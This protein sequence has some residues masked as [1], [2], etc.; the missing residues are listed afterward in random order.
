[1]FKFRVW[2]LFLNLSSSL[3]KDH[4]NI[5]NFTRIVLALKMRQMIHPLGS[6]LALEESPAPAVFP[7]PPDESPA[8]SLC[9]LNT[10]ETLKIHLP[11]SSDCFPPSPFQQSYAKRSS[12]LVAW[13]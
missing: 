10:T 5:S 1:I 3:Q 6:P 7:G 8:A 2:N 9:Q 12:C 4:R 13:Q 11:T